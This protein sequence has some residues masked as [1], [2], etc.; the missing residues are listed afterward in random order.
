MSITKIGPRKYMVR[1]RSLPGRDGKRVNYK[2]IIDGRHDDAVYLEATL[3]RTA[4]D[5]TDHRTLGAFLDGAFT[6]EKKKQVEANTWEYYEHGINDIKNLMGGMMLPDID[7]YACDSALRSMPAGS[8]RRRARK[9]LSV[10]LSVAVGLRFIPNNPMRDVVTQDG[11]PKPKKDKFSIEEARDV[12]A[13][14]YGHRYETAVIL[15]MLCG[16]RKEEVLGL[17]WEHVR[18]GDGVGSIEVV[19]A[20]VQTR[21][22]PREKGTKNTPSQRVVPISGYVLERLTVLRNDIGPVVTT[23]GMRTKPRTLSCAYDRYMAKCGFRKVPFENLR[24]TYASGMASS[25]VSL[26]TIQRLLGHAKATTTNE[27]LVSL[28]NDREEAARRFDMLVFPVP[29]KPVNGKQLEAE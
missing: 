11:C 16:L 3:R 21:D 2:Q 15:S 18:F 12:A 14:F 8:T 22:G 29:E 28:D 23:D 24:H 25:G 1:C 4:P 7:T 17:N 6:D 5:E 13:A 26:A 20:Y 10:A 27:Y 9:T 19:S